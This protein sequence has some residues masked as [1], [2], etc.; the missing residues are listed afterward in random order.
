MLDIGVCP[1]SSFV[2]RELKGPGTEFRVY[3]CGGR[4]GE[5]EGSL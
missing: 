5:M 3:A 4:G 2:S 1:Y